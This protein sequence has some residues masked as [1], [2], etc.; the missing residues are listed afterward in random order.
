LIIKLLTSV[1]SVLAGLGVPIL[2]VPFNLISTKN[3][4]YFQ[5]K[6]MKARD[7]KAKIATEALQGI[8]Q[9]KFSA[10]ELQWQRLI[11]IAREAE[12]KEIWSSY[13]WASVMLFC[14]FS[15][16]IILGGVVLGLHAWING[17]MQP[18][19]AFTSLAIFGKL[20][21]CLNVVPLTITDF[22]D[23]KVS[24]ARIEDYLDRDECGNTTQ[25]G[26]SISFKDAH[27]RWPSED[28]NHSLFALKNLN[29]EF[30]PGELRYANLVCLQSFA[31]Q[32]TTASYVEKRGQEKVYFLQQS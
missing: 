32:S 27:V 23:A 5:G 21:W 2:F 11:Q 1:Y 4:A 19:I 12:L 20:E 17:G 25:D 16:P 9:I 13:F 15:M 18:S 6:V 28:D 7:A 22:Y 10:T 29:M 26:N 24:I 3:Y 8:R 14:W 30:P 31:D